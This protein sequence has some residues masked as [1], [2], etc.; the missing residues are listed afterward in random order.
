MDLD[1]LK[2]LVADDD[3]L[4]RN[5]I[6]VFLSAHGATV[7]CCEDGIT[8]YHKATTR[9]FDCI[10]SDINMP[11]M[12]GLELLSKIR[13]ILR[14][15]TPLILMSGEGKLSEHEV[16]YRG[17]QAF[18]KKPFNLPALKTAIQTYSN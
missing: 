7:T 15:E 14:D 8:A 18:F 16:I 9:K 17:A 5:L 12:S 3:E 4:L 6:D 13:N 10:I 2:I 11:L 1:K